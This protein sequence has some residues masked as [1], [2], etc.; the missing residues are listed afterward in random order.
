MVYSKFHF[1]MMK[2]WFVIV[3]SYR[4]VVV[5][6]VV[7]CV[8]YN[9]LNKR[10]LFLVSV[11]AVHPKQSQEI[12]RNIRG[13]SAAPNLATET[14]SGTL[15]TNSRSKTPQHLVVDMPPM[16]H[17]DQDYYP[18]PKFRPRHRNSNQSKS[19]EEFLGGGGCSGGG[20]GKGA[21][22]RK[23]SQTTITHIEYT[24]TRAHAA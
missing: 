20:G 8:S 15:R 12:R 10:I 23:T 24:Y 16:D 9:V 19:R 3:L 13:H 22:M 7:D 14:P 21:Y 17:P 11:F 6:V 4:G 5:V 1:V 18:K 2:S